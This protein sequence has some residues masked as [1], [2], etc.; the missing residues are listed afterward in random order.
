[1]R[2]LGRKKENIGRESE[3]LTSSFKNKLNVSL[4]GKKGKQGT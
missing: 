4:K 2:E 1:V 3:I